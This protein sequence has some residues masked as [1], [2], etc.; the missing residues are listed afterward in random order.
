MV[1]PLQATPLT[2]E[3][4]ELRDAAMVAEVDAILAADVIAV[5]KLL[6]DFATTGSEPPQ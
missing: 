6:A 5:D 2:T 4:A 1:R 3:E